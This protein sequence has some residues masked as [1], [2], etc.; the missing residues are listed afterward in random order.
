MLL[1]LDVN[2]L[3]WHKVRCI[4]D[5]PHWQVRVLCDA[6]FCQM[7][8]DGHACP[9]KM[10]QLPAPMEL[11]LIRWQRADCLS[12]MASVIQLNL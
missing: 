10:T 8:L 11:L 3:S 9:C 5:S 1:T 6:E 4:Q 12:S 2:K 7:S